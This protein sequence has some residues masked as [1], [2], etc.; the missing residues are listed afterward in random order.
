[1]WCNWSNVHFLILVKVTHTPNGLECIFLNFYF[2][3]GMHVIGEVKSQSYFYQLKVVF[4]D[5]FYSFVIHVHRC[6]QTFCEI[7]FPF[8]LTRNIK[9]IISIS[10]YFLFSFFCSN[11]WNFKL[12]LLLLLSLCKVNNLFFCYSRGIK[13]KINVLI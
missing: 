1:M 11:I 12:F 7:C 5:Y 8:I 3:F 10:F 9:Q 4:A 6:L 13:N 2:F